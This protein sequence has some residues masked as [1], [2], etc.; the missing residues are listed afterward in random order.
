MPSAST[1]TRRPAPGV[2]RLGFRARSI[3]GIRIAMMRGLPVQPD[4]P[5]WEIHGRNLCGLFLPDRAKL[6]S[7]PLRLLVPGV[8]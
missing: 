6:V 8:S 2:F 3:S 5:I 7:R 1:L 4:L